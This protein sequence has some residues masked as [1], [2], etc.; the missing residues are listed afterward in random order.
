MVFT[1]CNFFCLPKAWVLAESVLKFSDRRLKIF[2][3]DRKI[4]ADFSNLPDG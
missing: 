3:C 4:D 1:V 2:L